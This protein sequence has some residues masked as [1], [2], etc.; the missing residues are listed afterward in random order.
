[1]LNFK[2]KLQ[3]FYGK[4]FAGV[5]KS[6]GY[7]VIATGDFLPG[8]ALRSYNVIDG[9]VKFYRVDGCRKMTSKGK[10]QVKKIEQ[11]FMDNLNKLGIVYINNASPREVWERIANFFNNETSPVLKKMADRKDWIDE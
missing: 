11:Q 7:F 1:M 8:Y 3:K 2:K 5:S 4:S 6:G 9:M 10:E